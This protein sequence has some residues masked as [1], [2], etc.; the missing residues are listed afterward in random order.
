MK[1]ILIVVAVAIAVSGCANTQGQPS[2]TSTGVVLGGLSGALIGAA[3]GGRRG[4]QAAL[5]GGLIGAAVGGAIGA[6]LDAESAAA[7]QRAMHQ[8]AKSSRYGQNQTRWSNPS[9]AA[10]GTIA[11]TSTVQNIN[12]ERCMSVVEGV[13]IGGQMQEVEGLRCLNNNG[14]WVDRG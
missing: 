4:G 3:V 10:A 2:N 14:V 11:A 8:L 12:G 1:V 5:V 13:S 6:R 9:Q 7:R